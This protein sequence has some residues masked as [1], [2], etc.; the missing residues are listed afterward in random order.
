[1]YSFS[2]LSLGFPNCVYK[3]L[4]KSFIISLFLFKLLQFSLIDF[5]DIFYFLLIFLS[6]QIHFIDCGSGNIKLMWYFSV[7][8]LFLFKFFIILFILFSYSLNFIIFLSENV[9]SVLLKIFYFLLEGSFC[10][11][12]ICLNEFVLWVKFF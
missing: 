4:F 3:S 8:S 2:Y 11:N 6:L 12:T 5:I 9:K 7:L 1:M 10:V